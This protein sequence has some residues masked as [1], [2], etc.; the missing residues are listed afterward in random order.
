GLKLA[1]HPG[2]AGGVSEGAVDEDDGWSRCHACSLGSLLV[3]VMTIGPRPHHLIGPCLWCGREGRRAGVPPVCADSPGG[4]VGYG[5]LARAGRLNQS[6]GFVAAQSVRRARRGPA[7]LVRETRELTPSLSKMWRRWVFTVCGEM[8][9]VSA[10]SRLVLPPQ[11]SSATA[12]PARCR[13]SQPVA[14]RSDSTIR[15]RTPS[16][17]SRR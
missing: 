14:G 2:I 15:R 5:A 8:N 11:A 4:G 9:N 6:A 12:A 7:I 17:L 10:L 3:S 1:D 13:A 16:C